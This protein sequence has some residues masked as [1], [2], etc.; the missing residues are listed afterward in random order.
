MA[1]R[2]YLIADGFQIS[3]ALLPESVCDGAKVGKPARAPRLER[4]ASRPCLPA[5]FLGALQLNTCRGVDFCATAAKLF[6]VRCDP[7][8]F[9]TQVLFRCSC[10]DAN[11]SAPWIVVP[12]TATS[13]TLVVPEF[14]G[15]VPVKHGARHKL[16]LTASIQGGDP[17]LA[18][19]AN[20]WVEAV[21]PPLVAALKGAS[22]YK[23]N[24]QLVL[25][26]SGSYDP[27]GEV[28]CLLAWPRAD[29][30]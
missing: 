25:S 16:T 27:D 6:D 29:S 8:H 10:V 9:D 18:A 3:T 1:D 7:P 22:N 13:K 2:K 23:A 12:A 14:G 4:L 24:R 11:T 17:N 19:T 20:L 28:S 26:A 5:C 15:S 30:Y 21:G